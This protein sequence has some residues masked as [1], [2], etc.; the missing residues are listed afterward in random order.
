[1]TS[2]PSPWWW[3][4]ADHDQAAGTRGIGSRLDE[5]A[6]AGE[7][8]EDVEDVAGE[9]GDGAELRGAGEP[10]EL[11]GLVAGGLAGVLELELEVPPSGQTAVEVGGAWGGRLEA[12]A[13]DGDEAGLA[14]VDEERRREGAEDVALDVGLDLEPRAARRSPC[15]PDAVESSGR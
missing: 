5:V 13:L 1:M 8:L 3:M 11:S 4:Q 14:L 9:D 6:L 10:C 7:R 12:A 15:S 2:Y